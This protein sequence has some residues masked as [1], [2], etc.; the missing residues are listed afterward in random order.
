MNKKQFLKKTSFRFKRFENKSY[1]AYNSMHKAVTIGVV[2]IMT[3]TFANATRTSAQ[4]ITSSEGYMAEKT[5]EGFTLVDDALPNQIGK[6]VTIITAQE[7]ENLHAQSVA[8]LLTTIASVDIQTRGAHGIQSDVS[9]RGG[10]FDQTAI[11]LD[12]INISNPHTGHYSMDIPIS[13][14]DI[15]RIEII[16]GPSAIIYGASAFSGG[17]NIITKKV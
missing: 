3:L 7:I 16:K 13:I 11:L 2:S 15:E 6:V 14:Q 17:I 1:S 4:V 5:L 9:L 8:E 12:G 10:N